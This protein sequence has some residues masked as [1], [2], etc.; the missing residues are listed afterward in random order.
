MLLLLMVHLLLGVVAVAAVPQAAVPRL[1]Q[2]EAKNVRVQKT[3][4]APRR[5]QKVQ[6][7]P[8]P[9]KLQQSPRKSRRKRKRQLQGVMGLQKINV[10]PLHLQAGI[11]G[12]ESEENEENAPPFTE[13][14]RRKLAAVAAAAAV[15]AA[16]A[17]RRTSNGM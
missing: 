13:R 8:I 14:S 16:V 7:E 3:V 4:P 5:K 15:V 11:A 10:C 1:Q 17:V 12:G 2:R 9:T 6:K